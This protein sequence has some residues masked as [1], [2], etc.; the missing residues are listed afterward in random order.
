M[1]LQKAKAKKQEI[2]K[3]AEKYVK[4]HRQRKREQLALKR[5]AAK[6]ALQMSITF[7]LIFLARQLLRPRGAQARFRHPHPWYQP[8]APPPQ[9]GALKMLE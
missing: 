6:V 8:D 7:L 1:F 3:R 9:E 5:T 4:E 2:F